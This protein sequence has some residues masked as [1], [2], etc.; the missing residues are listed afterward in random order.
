M[1][2]INKNI[3]GF[4]LVETLVALSV[5]LISIAAPLT[6]ASKSLQNIYYARDQYIAT[7][8]AQEGVE[9]VI[10]LQRNKI[11]DEVIA[12]TPEDSWDWYTSL[13]NACTSNVNGCAMD[14]RNNTTAPVWV[15]NA[16]CNTTNC[17]INYNPTFTRARYS[18]QSGAGWVATPFTRQIRV[19][20][21][22]NGFDQVMVESRVTWSSNLFPAP[23]EVIM[24]TNLYNI[25]TTTI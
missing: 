21:A 7:M 20:D 4:S 11:N 22:G 13:P 17:D 24:R 10:S 15:N 3:R 9:A 6:I 14:F 1:I 23:Q 16:P 5:L 2:V 12:G 25:A 18:H 19:I 8:L